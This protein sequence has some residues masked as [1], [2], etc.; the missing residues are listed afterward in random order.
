MASE[1]YI[2][3]YMLSGSDILLYHSEM[4]EY[5]FIRFCIYTYVVYFSST[6]PNRVEFSYIP[7]TV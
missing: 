6:E 2:Y 7:E 5:K 4:S 3:V 1:I